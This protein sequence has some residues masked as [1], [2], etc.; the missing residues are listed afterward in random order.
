LTDMKKFAA[1]GLSPES[2]EALSAKGF[3]EPTP[4]QQACI[5]LLL[6]G[7]K[8]VVGQ[9]QTG[10]GKTAAFGLPILDLVDPRQKVIQ[11][12]ILTPTRELAL[13]ITEEMSSYRGKRAHRIV[14]IYGGQSYTQQISRIQSGGQ[15]VVGTPGRVL[16]LIGRGK[17]PLSNVQL[18]VLDEADEMLNLGFIDD[19]E[20]ILS[21]APDNRRMLLFSATMPQRILKLA[22]KYMPSYEHIQVKQS[23]LS[24]NL[25]DQI[26]FEVADRDKLEALCRIIDMEPD[27]YGLIF[28]RTKLEVDT[29]ARRLIDRGYSAEGIHGD[30][31]QAQRER[32]YH[33]FKD[34]SFTILV[35]TDVAARGIDVSNLTHV[36]NYALPQD[37]ESYVHR[38]GRT[39][40]AGKKGTAITF[41]T[42][43][44]YRKLIA[45]SDRTRNPIR[46]Q[47]LPKAADVVALKQKR[48]R[49]E[50]SKLLKLGSREA[51]TELAANLLQD[52]SPEDVVAA[53]LKLSF[54]EE[55]DISSY[56]E[57]QTASVDRKGKNRLFV[58]KGKRD[59]MSK[60]DLVNF[61]TKQ[62]GIPS[63]LIDDVAVF[64]EFSFITVPFREGERILHAFAAESRGRRPLVTKA[65]GKS[66]HG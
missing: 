19:V 53:L 43:Y 33:K 14:P 12:I 10:T 62:A 39:G 21:H 11:A 15:I 46:K 5:P 58:A 32:T 35:A 3:E 25:T 1:L 37:P 50:V 60:G 63:H 57:I 56:Q 26:Y 36:V 52:Q 8:P 28:C 48:I 61:V 22:H 24:E 44:E 7:E 18:F 4:I 16:D 20:E 9:A 6:K 40:R 23:P 17:L 54:E 2:L 31:S 34:K 29:V 47:N 66:P 49:D 27:F 38:I 64:E 55:L 45:I 51:Y 42:P 41:I 65:R 30:I 13:Q 59:G